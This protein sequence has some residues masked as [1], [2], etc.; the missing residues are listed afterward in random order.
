M[1][2]IE[3]MDVGEVRVEISETEHEYVAECWTTLGRVNPSFTYLKNNFTIA[4][5]RHDLSEKVPV[6]VVLTE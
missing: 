6:M 1:Q 2:L 5:V 3:T 4:D